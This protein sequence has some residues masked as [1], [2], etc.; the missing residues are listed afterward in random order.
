MHKM[1][2]SHDGAVRRVR[3]SRRTVSMRSSNSPASK[4]GSGLVKELEFL[5][6]GLRST[7]VRL[8]ARTPM[9]SL[10]R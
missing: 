9:N 2:C 5:T 7:E 6:G 1:I 10:K 3:L 8:S 4:T